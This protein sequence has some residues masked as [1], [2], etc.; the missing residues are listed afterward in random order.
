LPRP[1]RS[2]RTAGA[3]GCCSV[4]ATGPGRRRRPSPTIRRARAYPHPG[5]AGSEAGR[6]WRRG[7]GLR[8]PMRGPIPDL[9]RSHV[10]ADIT[11]LGLAGVPLA[12]AGAVQEP[13]AGPIRRYVHQWQAAA[14]VHVQDA[15]SAASGG[16]PVARSAM[17]DTRLAPLARNRGLH[18]PRARWRAAGASGCG[19]G[20]DRGSNS[21]DTCTSG[22]PS[23]ARRA[24]AATHAQGGGRIGD[25]AAAAGEARDHWR[26]AAMRRLVSGALVKPWSTTEA[27]M[28]TATTLN[29]GR[30]SAGV[31][32]TKAKPR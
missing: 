11:R 32:A 8:E 22:K 21:G 30:A 23:A 19:S 24:A 31:M 12:Q 7:P 9:H 4:T 15:G 2:T 18:P 28:A 26:S 3:C 10:T 1:C 25:Q 29:S 27:R 17:A 16:R 20:A 6:P 5:G 14:A 13:I